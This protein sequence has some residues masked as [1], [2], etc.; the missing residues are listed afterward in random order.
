MTNFE[1]VLLTLSAVFF[2]MSFWTLHKNKKWHDA[3]E[4]E[5]EKRWMRH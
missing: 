2:V 4:R 5:R 3:K 1:I